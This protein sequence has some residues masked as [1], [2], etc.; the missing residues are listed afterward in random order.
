LPKNVLFI[1]AIILI[2]LPNQSFSQEKGTLRGVVVDSTNGEALPYG[3]VLIRELQAGASTDHRGYFLIPSVPANVTYHLLISYVGYDQ[4]ELVINIAPNRVTH[5]DIPLAPSSV[6]LE[7]IEK[8]GSRIAEENATDIGVQRMTERELEASPSGVETDVLRSLQNMPGV[9]STGDVSARYYVRGGTSNQNLVLLEGA[10][11]YNPFH[12]LGMFSAIDPEMLNNVEFYKG[13]FTAEYGGRV[14][15]VL[16]LITKD[17]NKYNYSAKVS[18]SQ[19]TMKGL[20]EGP[21]PHGSFIITGR[22]SYSDEILKK[23]LNDQNAP[24]DFYDFSFKLN[25]SDPDF[26]PISKFT[27]HGFISHDELNH[28]D[29]Y[30]EDFRWENKVLGFKWFNAPN[31]PLFIELNLTYSSFEGEV[32]PN[33]SETKPKYN[34]V[35][36]ITLRTDFT[37][38]FD[39]KDEIGIGVKLMDLQTKL[40]IA[41][42]SGI[43]SDI[44]SNGTHLSLYGKYKFLR[45]DNFGIDVGSRFNVIR[46]AAGGGGKYNLE[47]RVSMTYR[48]FPTMALKAAI[49]I[50]QQDLTTLSDESEMISLFEPWLITPSYLDPARAVHY[51][52]GLETDI[53]SNWSFDIEAYYKIVDDLPTINNEKYL[54]SDPDL[55]SGTG[56]SYG[57]EFLTK[58]RGEIV[59]FTGSY[60][61]S[62]AY[63]EVNDWLYYPRYDSRHNINLAL[64]VDFGKGWRMSTV[65]VYNSSLPF[66]QT[67]G[68]YDKL[69]LQ[70]LETLKEVYPFFQPYALLSDINLGRLPNYHRMDISLNKNIDL[71]WIKCEL[72]ISIINVYN[73]ENLFYYTRE[74][75]ERVNMLP[76]LLSGTIKVQI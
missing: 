75:N 48:F 76:F 69:Y 7:T 38:V 23:F 44:G 5:L 49:G 62:W 67:F 9:R 50:Y 42:S 40:L 36:D 28:N 11:I 24:L 18:L 1:I 12:A 53:T 31:S 65:W 47:P 20:F 19:L 43:I 29:P 60:T 45:F 74:T 35:E 34:E 14:S 6:E 21:L 41:N 37:Y 8:V 22:K 15:S 57:W 3:N 32:M 54:S 33:L 56:T 51:T 27:L 16:S 66:T 73:R 58:Y 2:F 10:P 25:Y 61:L 59:N 52:V 55:I 13:G 63:K 46:L 71:S 17:G 68:Y 70:E 64:E 26:A 4:K 72:G 30:L 39:S